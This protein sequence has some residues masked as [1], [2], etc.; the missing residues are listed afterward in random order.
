MSSLL[1]NWPEK[2]RGPYLHICQA[3]VNVIS[4]FDS[5]RYDRSDVDMLSP[6]MRMHVSK[7]LKTLGFKQ[8]SGNVFEHSEQG[9]R[10]IIPKSHAL[11]A[12]P[13][14]IVDYTSKREQDYY[15]L[16][17]TQTACLI[18]KLHDLETAVARICELIQTQPI[19]IL[20]LSDY[21]D[22]SQEFYDF[23]PAIGHL[24]Y[25]QR[26]ALESSKLNKLKSLSIS[27]H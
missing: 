11:G 21:L 8:K 19:N 2:E 16:T 9:I 5:L 20:R 18:I 12:S 7:K 6:S 24:K 23:R 13:F 1:L 3:G 25:V 4:V 15:L 26:V 10:C 27:R 22:Y 14:H 17:P